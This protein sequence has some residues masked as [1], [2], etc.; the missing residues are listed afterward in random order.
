MKAEISN[1]E[2]MKFVCELPKEYDQQSSFRFIE[3]GGVNYGLVSHPLHL[4]L[5]VNLEDGT[6]RK[7]QI[8]MED[9]IR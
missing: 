2:G 1:R 9:V 3:I 4:P 6:F 8:H 7:V 5:I